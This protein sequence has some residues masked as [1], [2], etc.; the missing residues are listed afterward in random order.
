MNVNPRSIW[1][2]IFVVG[3]T[4]AAVARASTY[5]I[6]DSEFEPSA[7]THFVHV[8]FGSVSFSV[9]R[10]S[11]GGNPDSFQR[12]DHLLNLNELIGVV[13]LYDEASHD[14][15]VDG[16]IES[17]SFGLDF[18]ILDEGSAAPGDQV[19]VMGCL[20]QDGRIYGLGYQV[21]TYPDDWIAVAAGPSVASD[22][23][24]IVD[25]VSDWTDDESHPDFSSNGSPIRFGFLTI[26][27][28]PTVISSLF[29]GVDNWRFTVV[30][31]VPGGPVP[32]VSGWG[33][34]I[35]VMLALVTGSL[36][37]GGYS[38]RSAKPTLS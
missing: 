23:V 19:G 25:N 33:V 37:F 7:W 17:L 30:D 13:H 5:E 36:C 11:E 32:A 10:E 1:G 12:G 8:D 3:C 31:G 9:N 22:W 6:A 14:P 29:W 16:K 2:M 24:E 15:S 4:H 34:L 21:G 35:L 26:N 18:K 20:E 27:S 38:Y 28:S